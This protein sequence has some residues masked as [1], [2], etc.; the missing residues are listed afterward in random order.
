MSGHRVQWNPS[1][2][3][4]DLIC[5]EPQEAACRHTTLCE[6]ESF[7][8]Q[9]DDKGWYH[10]V[11]DVLDNEVRH[12]HVPSDECRYLVWWV[13]GDC[14]E[15]GPVMSTG[16]YDDDDNVIPSPEG[17]IKFKWDFDHYLW[18]WADAEPEEEPH[19]SHDCL[20]PVAAGQVQEQAVQEPG[21]GLQGEA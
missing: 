9:Q 18:E 19:G 16:S 20:Q 10:E 3:R 12:D 17:R 14:A 13:D 4:L 7:S 6:C 15:C 5:E 8:Q 2:E 11:L 21:D 1:S